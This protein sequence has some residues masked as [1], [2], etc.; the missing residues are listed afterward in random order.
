[1]PPPAA[2]DEAETAP[3]ETETL[4]RE[5]VVET[6]DQPTDQARPSEQPAA[7]TATSSPDRIVSAP[8]AT[9]AA[10]P[11]PTVARPLPSLSPAPLP[12]TDLGE[13]ATGEDQ[14]ITVRGSRSEATN[15]YIDG[16][17]VGTSDRAAEKQQNVAASVA[18]R[19]RTP[20]PFS[21]DNPAARYI[22]GRVTDEFDQPI[23][24]AH[25]NPYG[26]PVG[27][28]TDSSG[29]F[30]LQVDRGVR[31]LMVQTDG[32]EQLAVSLPA[33]DTGLLQLELI[34]EDADSR[35]SGP[36]NYRR[37]SI[38]IDK[39]PVTVTPAGGYRRLRDSLRA[40]RPTELPTGRVRLL[41]TINVAGQIG[42]FRV[43]RSPS[44]ALAEWVIEQLRQVEDWQVQ[45]GGE[46]REDV[47]VVYSI[48]FRP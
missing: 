38:V 22:E 7:S 41:F 31:N 39:Q 13:E 4:A 1:P 19:T 30:R 26:M 44:P 18:P 11:R 40:N 9:R 29:Y 20:A 34:E 27:E 10:P 23:A 45:G 28:F 14:A 12:A 25:V 46:S 24:G 48:L 32:Y 35:P 16:V 8:A 21:L 17:R 37:T 5:Q 36:Y 47:E 15:Y 42:K 3:A 43:E 33:R 2:S 6:A